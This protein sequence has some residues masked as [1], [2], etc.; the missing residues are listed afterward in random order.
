M[1]EAY[2]PGDFLVRFAG[3]MKVG[4]EACESDAAR[5]TEQW[6]TAMGAKVPEEEA[7]A[8]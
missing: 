7:A 8:E 4:L 3:C 5:F 1:G 6:R 2:E